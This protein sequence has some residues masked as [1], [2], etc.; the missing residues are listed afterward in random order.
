MPGRT[1]H[2]RRIATALLA[3]SAALTLTA[4]PA[5]ADSVDDLLLRAATKEM[6]SVMQQL[7]STREQGGAPTGTPGAPLGAPADEGP[8]P[9]VHGTP[10]VAPV[11]VSVTCRRRD[12][13]GFRCVARNRATQR[14]LARCEGRNRAPTRAR[15]RS[16]GERAGSVVGRASTLT[17][18]GFP[19]PSMPAVGRLVIEYPSGHGRCTGAVVSRTLV[20]T[21]AHCVAAWNGEYPTG[22]AFLPGAS[23]TSVEDPWDIQMPYGG[24]LAS[25]WWI[26]S[27]FA[28]Q[29]DAALDWALVEIPPTNAGYT[30]SD[31]TGA[32]SILPNIDFGNGAHIYASGYPASGFW[33]TSEGHLTR[34]QYA[35]DSTWDGYWGY[36]GT[37]WELYLNCTMNRG[38]SG[39]PWFVQLNDG[40][41]YIGGMN[42]RCQ[43]PWDYDA[44]HYCDPYSYWMRSTYLDSRFYDFWNSVQGLLSYRSQRASSPR[45]TKAARGGPARAV[46]SA[47]P[48]EQ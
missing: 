35:C 13:G 44:Q 27:G 4:G 30:I 33:A 41:W 21:A 6:Y 24:W 46:A 48:S 2:P 9:G 42:N 17:W 29:Q 3:A 23:W 14:V 43:S 39:G 26:T 38:A 34:G 11:R 12:R 18:Q 19:S 22:V 7:G 28:N 8:D 10:P 1:R 37:G 47:P 36:I 5:R 15:C 16:K 20:L 32:W 40:T 25:N 45:A 31:Y